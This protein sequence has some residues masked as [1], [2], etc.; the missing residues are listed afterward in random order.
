M[1]QLICLPRHILT[2]VV[3]TPSFVH[4]H[5]EQEEAVGRDAELRSTFLLYV[6]YSLTD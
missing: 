4:G 1:N 5:V 6:F 2:S 3:A